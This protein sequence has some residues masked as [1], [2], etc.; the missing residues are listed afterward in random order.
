MAK[1]EVV[2]TV[3]TTVVVNVEAEDA[4]DAEGAIDSEA[5]LD[6]ISTQ[7]LTHGLS[8]DWVVEEV[9]QY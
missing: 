8:F 9:N 2:L 1:Y 3:N 6:A 7:A 4:C 5:I